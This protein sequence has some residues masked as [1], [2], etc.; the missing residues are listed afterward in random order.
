MRV[1]GHT[2]GE[3]VYIGFPEAIF[4]WFLFGKPPPM[5][6]TDDTGVNAIG[7]PRPLL[8]SASRIFDPDPVAIYY[9]QIRGRIGMNLHQGVRGTLAQGWYLSPL[10]MEVVLCPGPGGDNQG[11]TLEEFGC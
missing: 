4:R 1:I 3:K 6:G 10:S 11:V 5:L 9:A 7:E 2:T 8:N